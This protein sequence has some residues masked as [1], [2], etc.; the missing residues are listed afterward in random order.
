MAKE[1][2]VVSLDFVNF[3]RRAVTWWQ[4]PQSDQRGGERCPWCFQA[5][6]LPVSTSD[7]A[8]TLVLLGCAWKPDNNSRL[9]NSQGN[10]NPFAL[11]KLSAWERRDGQPQTK[12]RRA[13]VCVKGCRRPV[14][15][16]QAFLWKDQEERLLV[17]PKATA[18]FW[19]YRD[20][21]Q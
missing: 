1:A 5:Y 3:V 16:L 19:L 20:W 10:P 9:S 8:A 7:H 14:L 17:L 11:W 12:K 15:R 4:I 18:L 6:C 13:A 2:V 21:K